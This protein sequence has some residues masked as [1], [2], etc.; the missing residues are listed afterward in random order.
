[1]NGDK[2]IGFM[3][4]CADVKFSFYFQMHIIELYSK[5]SISSNGIKNNHFTFFILFYFLAKFFA[6]SKISQL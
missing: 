2:C 6:I 5:H 1:M 3:N 4:L